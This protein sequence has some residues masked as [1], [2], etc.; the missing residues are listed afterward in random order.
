MLNTHALLVRSEYT[1]MHLTLLVHIGISHIH[2]NAYT[3][4]HNPITQSTNE[5]LSGEVDFRNTMS[6]LVLLVQ[7]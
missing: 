6:K 4:I 1:C 3:F 5:T 2:M 7:G